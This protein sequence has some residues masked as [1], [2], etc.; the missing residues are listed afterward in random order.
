ME[1]WSSNQNCSKA[2]SRTLVSTTKAAVKVLTNFKPTIPYQLCEESMLTALHNAHLQANGGFGVVTKDCKVWNRNF[3]RKMQIVQTTLQKAQILAYSTQNKP[4]CSSSTTEANVYND[5]W[6]MSG[7]EKSMI[8][9][10]G[11][12]K[13]QSLYRKPKPCSSRLTWASDSKDF[14]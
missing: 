9:Y 3:T 4:R 10:L 12:M 6:H 5:W 11:T 2:I 7:D 1:P 14:I 8:I 13:G